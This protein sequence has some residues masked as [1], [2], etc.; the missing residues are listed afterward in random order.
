MVYFISF[1]LLI[2]RLATTKELRMSTVRIV[3][4]NEIGY[5]R[6]NHDTE[7]IKIYTRTPQLLGKILADNNV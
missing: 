1:F 5:V 2:T 3:G 4:V 6:I 7:I